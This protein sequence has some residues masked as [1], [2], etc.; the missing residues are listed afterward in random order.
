MT[1]WYRLSVDEALEQSQ[2]DPRGLS[3]DEAARR[4]A[5]YGPNELVEAGTKSPWRIL[6]EQ[7]TSLLIIILIVAAVVSAAL[8]DYEDAIVILAIVVLN[9]VLGFRQEYKAEKTMTALRKLAAPIVRVRRD[10]EVREVPAATV[11][12]GD[13]VLIEAG[14]LVPADARVLESASLR[15]QEAALTGESEPVEKTAARL[16]ESE[17]PLG[18]RLNMLFMGTAA[19]YGRGEAV[20]TATGMDTELGKIAGMV[21]AVKPSPTP[22][23]RRLAQLGRWLAVA[24]L[25]LVIVIFVTGVLR[26]APLRIMFLT[27]VSMAVA[28]VPEGLPAIVTVALSLGAQRMLRRKALIRKLPA[29]ETLGSVTVICSDKTGTLTENRMTVVILDV[30]GHEVDLQE[31]LRR[32][33]V[34]PL[35]CAA[36]GD[37]APLIK[38]EPAVA[39]LVAGGVLCNDSVLQTTPGDDVCEDPRANQFRALGDP[40]EAALVMA[41]VHLGLLKTELEKAFPRTGELPFDS[42]RKMMTTRHAVPAGLPRATAPGAVT[43]TFGAAPFGTAPFGTADAESAPAQPEATEA[44][45]PAAESQAPDPAAVPVAALGPLAAYL[46]R[47]RADEF[48]LT[49]GAPEALIPLATAFWDGEQAVPLD[50]VIRNMVERRNRD[51]ASRGMRVLAVGFRPLGVDGAASGV[52]GTGGAAAAEGRVAPEGAAAVASAARGVV[53]AGGLAAVATGTATGKVPP[54]AFAASVPSATRGVVVAGVDA[55]SWEKDLVLVGLIGMIDPA[56][57]EAREAVLTATAAGIRPVMIT[58]DQPLTAAA[59]ARQVGILDGAAVGPGDGRTDIGGTD[60]GGAGLRAVA[61]TAATDAGGAGAVIGAPPTQE[62]GADD[63]LVLTGAQL[64]SLSPDELSREVDRIA[65]YARVAPEQKLTIVQALQD[66]GHIVAMTGD[67][68]NDAPALQKADI[69]VAMGVTGTDV[70][71]EAA[72]MV[73]LDDNFATIVAAVKE[74]RAIYDNIRKFIKYLMTTN[75]GELTVMLFAP[76]SGMPLPLLPL[77]ILWMNLVTDGLPGLALGFEP[78][79]P[80]VMQRRPNPPNESIFARGLGTHIIWAGPLMGVIALLTGWAYWHAGDESWQ[81]MLFTVL[82]LSQMAHVLAIH[83][84]RRSVFGRGFLTNPLLLWAVFL[85][86]ALQFALLYVPFLQGVFGTRALDLGHIVVALAIST[87]ILWVI[88]AQKLVLRLRDR[89]N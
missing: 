67:G 37:D 48:S 76:I 63:L 49:K 46:G 34:A 69:G 52:G 14:N 86:V 41:G 62:A 1:E 54:A 50:Q 78:A 19:S 71:K 33:R 82:T 64:A 12:P 31:E 87:A 84:E 8:G 2:G 29:V 75:V 72:D 26:G 80:D 21:Q 36:A 38:D 81:T 40:T 42:D 35:P 11:V 66:R 59:I 23:Q 83:Q 70:A 47:R 18:D 32:G 4:L 28:A 17:V 16:L 22:L 7:F 6:G 3:R 60:V 39:L 25:V 51:L 5:E 24:A 43:G 55:G 15:V 77:Q 61:G 9:G 88:E 68:V 79:E 44:K 89:H 45:P 74:G 13:I 85:T 20:V 57:A 30:A 58:G 27:A 73:L 65:V 56:R 10:G 53:A